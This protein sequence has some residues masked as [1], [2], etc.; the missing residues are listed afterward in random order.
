[1]ETPG[2]ADC[3]GGG[4]DGIYLE[5]T[6]IQVEMSDWIGLAEAAELLGVHPN[7]VRNW[8]DNGRIPVHR[9]GGNHRRFHREEIELWLE[10][11]RGNGSSSAGLLFQSALWNTRLQVSEGDL[12]KEDWYQKIDLRGREKYRSSGRDTLQSLRAYLSDTGANSQEEPCNIGRN[13]AIWA[14]RNGL[15]SRDA[16]RA[17]IFF[18]GILF[19]SMMEVFEQSAVQ[20]PQKWMVMAQKTNEFTD[21]VIQA[22]LDAYEE[23]EQ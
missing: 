13:Y 8:A 5:P 12:E 3:H 9:T 4:L 17:F 18:R 7:T 14:Y 10:S 21:R 6:R 20:E 2:H 23:Y 1:M 22:L 19:R 15:S 16:T 11:Q